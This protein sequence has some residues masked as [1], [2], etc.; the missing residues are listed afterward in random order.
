MSRTVSPATGIP[1]GVQRVCAAW[2]QARSTFYHRQ[3]R[4]KAAP[5]TPVPRKRGPKPRISDEALLERIRADLAAS[6][7]HGE[8]HRAVHRR[9]RYR[10]GIRVA[11][12]RVLDLMR[13]HNLLSPYR[14][15]R[16]KPRATNN[17]D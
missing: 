6:R 17:E 9:L 13:D 12:G 8:G 16:K 5:Q 2:E 14:G 1:Y 3:Q 15:R 11:R 10:H 4:I 7:F